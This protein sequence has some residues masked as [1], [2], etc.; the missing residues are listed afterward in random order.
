MD[1]SARANLLPDL[2]ASCASCLAPT[3]SMNTMIT[4]Y[5]MPETCGAAWWLWCW[6]FFAAQGKAAELVT[7]RG[8][9]S[10]LVAS[11]QASQWVRVSIL[12]F[13]H[14][15]NYICWLQLTG[16][17]I[18]D[19]HHAKWGEILW[20]STARL[21]RYHLV[22]PRETIQFSLRFSSWLFFNRRSAL[23][24][25]A[26][27]AGNSRKRQDN[28]PYNPKILGDKAYAMDWF[29]YQPWEIEIHLISDHNNRCGWSL[30]CGVGGLARLGLGIS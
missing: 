28:W 17:T 18:A 8:L 1:F 22:K 25:S 3:P 7:W 11:L 30:V 24:F 19:W 6:W 26:V 20:W 5:T 21:A 23:C 15:T 27:S 9:V 4:W 16:I 10:A 13:R 14:H 2:G 12:V 29:L